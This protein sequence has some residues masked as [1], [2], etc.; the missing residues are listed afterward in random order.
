MATLLK[1][2]VMF[3]PFFGKDTHTDDQ[4]SQKDLTGVRALHVPSGL[5]VVVQS[6]GRSLTHNKKRAL[7]ELRCRLNTEKNKA[8]DKTRKARWRKA[9]HNR[10]V[11]RSYNSPQSEVQSHRSGV[12]A[13]VKQILEGERGLLSL[14]AYFTELRNSM[15]KKERTK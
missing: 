13:S 1:K 3:E 5:A 8:G 15:A 14:Q 12:R 10:T 6:Q 2:D 11:I 9:I 7:E 4:Y